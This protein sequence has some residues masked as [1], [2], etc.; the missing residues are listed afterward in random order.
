MERIGARP[1]TVAVTAPTAF[2]G[3][4]TAFIRPML[5][6]RQM[7]AVADVICC[8]AAKAAMA[9]TGHRGGAASSIRNRVPRSARCY[10]ATRHGGTRT[11][12]P[13]RLRAEVDGREGVGVCFG[14]SPLIR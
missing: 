7:V 8:A 6:R 3:T 4:V 5:V 13:G 12:R 10:G 14:L 9:V 1:P 11:G 2:L